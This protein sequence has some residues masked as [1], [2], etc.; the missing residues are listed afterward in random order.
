M[1]Q[2]SSFTVSSPPPPSLGLNN[3]MIPNYL[4]VTLGIKLNFPK[5]IK[6]LVKPWICCVISAE[7]AKD[8][9]SHSI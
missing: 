3:S 8:I 9:S 2:F 4:G 5:H 1:L 7:C 6:E